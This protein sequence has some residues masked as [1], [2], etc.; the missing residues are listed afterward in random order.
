MSANESGST[1]P[2][3]QLGRKLR[4][5]REAAQQTVP[6]AIAALEWS[7]PR[8][9]RYETGQVPIHPNDVDAMCR[10]YGAPP[11]VTEALKELARQSKAKGW[12]HAY[13]EIPDWFEL[14]LGMEA[15]A[16]QIRQYEA[17]VIPGLLQTPAYA[18]AIIGQS[19]TP[20]TTEQIERQSTV[21]MQRQRILTRTQPAAPA[22]DVI[23]SEVALVRGFDQA[24]MV[25]QLTCLLT[26]TERPNINIRV[27][28]LTGG[29]HKA[30]RGPFVI[31]DFRRDSVTRDP[32]P[33]TIYVEQPTG[34]L[35]LEKASE[36]AAFEAIWLDL[37]DRVAL[38]AAESRRL[39]T[40]RVKEWSQ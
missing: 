31:L 14:F 23:L 15:V 7:K 27:V 16:A 1:V 11:D 10:V 34:A 12:W 32:E 40:Q 20:P 24:T 19:I 21:R 37:A 8:L 2:R 36:V 39:I 22:L 30:F 13:S 28:P 18:R 38:D 25:D 17:E 5:L 35:Y 26:Y 9:W 4:E 3:R 6:Q 29:P 33:T